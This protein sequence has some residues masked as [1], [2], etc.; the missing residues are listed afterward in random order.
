MPLVGAPILNDVSSGV[1][2]HYGFTVLSP[3][4]GI[5]ARTAALQMRNGEESRTCNCWSV[6]SKINVKQNLNKI[7]GDY[8]AKLVSHD[9]AC[10][11]RLV[12]AVSILALGCYDSMKLK[13]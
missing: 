5:R 9:C 11:S 1:T 6:E 12:S 8:E 4:S 2:R 13:N 10:W 3:I 7:A